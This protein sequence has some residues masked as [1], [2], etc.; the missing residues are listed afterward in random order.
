MVSTEHTGQIE[1]ILSEDFMLFLDNLM[2]KLEITLQNGE[3]KGS[4]ICKV[5]VFA[6][7]E[8]VEL[9]WDYLDRNALTL[10]ELIEKVG[11][12]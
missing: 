7:R 3:V 5:M 8:M 2:T 9:V 10:D 1:I 11:G 6:K 12:A 4:E